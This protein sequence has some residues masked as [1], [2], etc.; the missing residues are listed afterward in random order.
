MHDT[1]DRE[2]LVRRDP[3]VS[4]DP[5]DPIVAYAAGA[6]AGILAVCETLDDGASALAAPGAGDRPERSRSVVQKF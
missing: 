2:G 1:A 3:A 4:T 6:T 5:R